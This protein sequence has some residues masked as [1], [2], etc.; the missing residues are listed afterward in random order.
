[1]K[2][3][4]FLI[5]IFSIMP[6]YPLAHLFEKQNPLERKKIVTKAKILTFTAEEI[7]KTLETSKYIKKE[8][9]L[10]KEHGITFDDVQETVRFIAE[11]GKKKPKLLKSPWF[12]NTYFDWYR[13]YGDKSQQTEIMPKGWKGAPENIRTTTY[14][15]IEIPGSTK[16]TKKYCCGLYHL[17]KDERVYRPSQKSEHRNKLLRFKYSR[18]EIFNGALE[19]NK[20]T[21]PVAWL[22]K[23]GYE[24]LAMQ[25]TSLIR[26]GKN[27][28]KFFG[29]EGHNG[30]D[31]PERYWFV[32]DIE[33][34]SKG[35]TIQPQPGVTCAG[36][37]N[38]L[39]FGKTI[40]LIGINPK[41]QKEEM[42][43]Q[44][45]V[46]SGSAFKN[47]LSKLDLFAGYFENDAAFK[48]QTASYP[49]TARAYILI[50]KKR[51]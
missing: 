42:R 11:V 49:H 2:F 47:N 37:I 7:V 16:K 23:K 17:P 45:L 3:T 25:G 12:Y 27:D 10:L 48:A 40:A 30:R 5:S 9:G 20:Q 41:T 46:D 44:F 33:K 15:I 21:Y 29:V 4:F 1:M 28:K 43:L 26:F 31:E 32:S 19:G 13:W 36:D 39:G 50:K 51:S 35:H 6:L 38:L 18:S 8:P 24:E 22:T 14:R 34:R